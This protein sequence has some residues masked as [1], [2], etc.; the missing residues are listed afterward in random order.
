MSEAVFR[1]HVEENLLH[2]GRLLRAVGLP[3]GSGQILDAVRAVEAVGVTRRDGVYWALAACFVRRREELA[4]FDEAFLLYFREPP[5]HKVDYFADFIAKSSIPRSSRKPQRSRRLQEARDRAGAAQADEA[6]KERIEFDVTMAASA[7][8]TFRT[9]DFEKMSV[10]EVRDAEA[11]IRKLLLAT[12][13]DRVKTRRL[14]AEEHGTK[15]DLRRTLRAMLRDGG[16]AL[17]LRW[18]GPKTQPPP[19]IALC[20]VSGSME[21]YSRIVLHFLHALTRQRRRVS[22]FTFG[23]RLTNVTRRLRER[24]VDEALASIGNDVTDWAGGTRIGESLRVFNKVW[25]RRV[26]AQKGAV[27]LLITDGLE[28]GDQA[29]LR[30][31][32]ERLHKSCGRLVW[33]NPL[34]RYEGFEPLAAGV[35]T[36]LANVDEFRPVHDLQ[37]LEQLADVLAKAEPRGGASNPVRARRGPSP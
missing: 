20:D 14:R 10:N 6:K 24:D 1:G 21:R 4:I 35:R 11:A 23:T 27:V 34:L 25:S 7:A 36:I 12:A 5:D 31:E 13:K 19:V 26:L 2:F 15:V 28:R 32:I 18:R 3:I 16:D 29:E 30:R 37:S 17:P 33:L 22:S 9:R 8:E